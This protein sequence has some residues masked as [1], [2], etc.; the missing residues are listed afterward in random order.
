MKKQA[1]FEREKSMTRRRFFKLMSTAGLAGAATTLSGCLITEEQAG[2]KGWLPEQYQIPAAWPAQVRGRIAIDP[3]NPSIT[4]DDQKC[5]LCGQ[6]L[7]V[8]QKQQSVFGYYDLP[9]Q[10][11]DFYICVNCGQ[12]S[13]WCPS[14]A[15][16]EKKNIDKVKQAL[17]DPNKVV[18][19]QTAPATRVGLGE[20]FGLPVGTW[21]QG[22]QVAALKKLGFDKVFDTNFTADLTIMEEGTELI[23]RLTGKSHGPVPQITSCCPGWVK[24]CEYYY[25]DL[26]PNLSSAKSP[27][28]MLGA[29]IKTYYAEKNNIDPEKIFSVS[30]MPCTA[31]KFESERPEFNSAGHYWKKEEIRDVD[32]V[33]TTRELA[34]LIKEAG[35]DL[36]K[37]PEEQ[38][39]NMLSE[40]SGAG[41]IFGNT[42][43][44]MQAAIRSAYFLLTGKQCPPEAF[45]LKDIQGVKGIKEGTVDIPGVGPLRVAVA[46]GLKNARTLMEAVRKG[47]APYHFIEIMACE[48][49]CISGGG[50]PRTA[51]PPSN[52]V[53]E[54]RIAN[55][56][57]KDASYKLRESHENKEVLEL[58]ETFLEHPISHLSHELLH[59][60][61]TSRE[62]KLNS[63]KL[64]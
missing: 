57:N 9:L 47:E 5:I 2:G 1:E 30:V 11:D 49:G 29:I 61:Y 38:Y 64:V 53:R 32:A 15:I 33:L 60:T 16:K 20:E 59:T 34:E 46:H 10:S 13:N 52:E 36:N 25:P 21:V 48:G 43:G 27:Q 41:L 14:S 7:E 50:Q 26:I 6:C 44:V 22:Q 19:V 58:Y 54:M 56:Y 45:E 39:D 12:C 24:F 17:A 62:K 63:K 28:Q 31:K 3:Q 51:V 35:L 23:Q 42:G 4:R 18:I 40:G 37:L 55:I 8:C